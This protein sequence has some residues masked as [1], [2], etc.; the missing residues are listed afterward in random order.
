MPKCLFNLYIVGFDFIISPKSGLT[1]HDPREKRRLR[2]TEWF[3]KAPVLLWL[4]KD[5]LL[6]LEFTLRAL[7]YIS[8]P[9]SLKVKL[10]KIC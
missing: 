5:T 2:H 9:L 1:L 6:S 8:C 4:L 7:V 10:R 3:A